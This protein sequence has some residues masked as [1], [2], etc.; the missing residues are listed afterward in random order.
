MAVLTATA[1]LLTA[2]SAQAYTDWCRGGNWGAPATLYQSNYNNII[3]P[4]GMSSTTTQAQAATLADGVA[5]DYAGAGPMDM[6]R[7][8]VDPGTVSDTTAW[9]R[10]QAAINE[11]IADG[12]N[13]DICCFYIEWDTKHGGTGLIPSL[14]T[15]EAM[16]KTID[17]VYGTSASVF[18]EPINEPFNYSLTSLEGVYNDFIDLKLKKPPGFCLLDGTGYA[19]NV[20]GIGGDSAFNGYLLAV[21]DYPW[22]ATFPHPITDAD[23]ANDLKSRIGTYADRTIMTE[24]GAPTTTGLNYGTANSDNTNIC[25]IRGMCDQCLSDSMGFIYYPAHQAASIGND[26]RLFID[27]PGSLEFYNTSMVLELDYGWGFSD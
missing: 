9:K 21:H 26:K 14:G 18:Y 17:S 13:V 20:T 11:L 10:T 23:W 8:P 19:D 24:M 2:A 15:W 4:D 12:M 1:A 25:F 3:Y 5:L 27:P 22:Y 6:V 16:W 7:Y